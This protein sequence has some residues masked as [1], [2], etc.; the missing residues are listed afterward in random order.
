MS[1]TEML[2]WQWQGYINYHQSRGNLVIHWLAVPLFITATFTMLWALIHAE[3]SNAILAA[4]AMA[5]AM[6]IQGLGHA[7]E[8]LPVQPF[9]D[10]KEAVLRVLLEQFVTFPRFFSS[11]SWWL[12]Y[13][14]NSD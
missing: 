1:I 4:L 3:I 12:V 6:L 7:A 10:V 9:K 5:I 11:A 13:Q 2:A 8:P 14:A